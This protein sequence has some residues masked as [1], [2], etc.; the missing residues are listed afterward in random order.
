MV[1]TVLGRS[2]GWRAA[3]SA[4]V[5]TVVGSTLAACGSANNAGA[6]NPPASISTPVSSPIPK[7]PAGPPTATI[8]KNVI[9]PTTLTVSTGAT[10]EIKNLDAISHNLEDKV[11]RLYNGD[12][13]AKGSEELTA[14]ANP[15]T[16]TF[17]DRNHSTLKFTLKV[18]D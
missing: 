5:L 3:R 17:I 12:V 15:G 13:P 1:A 11:H 6:S 2:R 18:T 4:A 10:V 16:Y 14:P 7:Q 9:S 8:H